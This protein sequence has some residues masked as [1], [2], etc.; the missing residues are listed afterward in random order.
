MVAE[1]LSHLEVP[2]LCLTHLGV[3]LSPVSIKMLRQEAHCNLR[4]RWS[5]KRP[6]SG[7][8]E[9]MNVNEYETMNYAK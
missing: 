8:R 6:V 7:N 9:R 2:C 3:C 5:T 4:P 1:K